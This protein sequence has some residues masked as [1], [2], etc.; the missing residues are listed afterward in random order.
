MNSKN[1]KTVMNITIILAISCM[2]MYMIDAYVTP[3]YF[4]K[5]IYKLSFFGIAPMIY[6]AI[7]KEI[8]V[9]DF[10]RLPTKKQAL[11]SLVLGIGVYALIL[12]GYFL[13]D[14]FIDLQ[15]IAKQLSETMNV[16][17]GNFLYVAFYIAIANSFLEEFFFRGFA[18]LTYKKF[19]NKNVAYF[20]S[21]LAFALYHIAMLKNW[22]SLL[23]YVLA[24]VGL[25]IAGIIF[26]F[27]DEKSSNIYNSWLVHMFANFAINTVGLMMFG[28]L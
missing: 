7:D 26:N 25:F 8:K 23:L 13:L 20:I 6:C 5:S 27:L 28:I 10:F 11:V 9:K 18:F 17:K 12:G 14:S 19:L 2:A 21:A 1:R 4:A 15:N 16:N 3:T 22:F 24:I